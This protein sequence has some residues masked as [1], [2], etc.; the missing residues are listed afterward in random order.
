V[1]YIPNRRTYTNGEAAPFFPES[2]QLAL[3][4][5]FSGVLFVHPSFDA[6]FATA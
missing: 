2:P 4:A 6:L 3:R 5:F 1:R